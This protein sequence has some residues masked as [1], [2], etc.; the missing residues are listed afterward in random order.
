MSM[1]SREFTKKHKNLNI[2]KMKQIF[3]ENSLFVIR[4]TLKAI[5]WSEK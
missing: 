1:T 4:Y 3:S 5:I 2:L